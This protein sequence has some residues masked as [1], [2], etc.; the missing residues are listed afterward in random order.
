ML[1]V[2]N[3][4]VRV[5]M[6]DYEDEIARYVELVSPLPG[7]VAVG[8][9]GSVGT[10][11]YSDVDYVLIVDGSFDPRNADLL[12]QRHPERDRRIVLHA[13][14]IVSAELYREFATHLFFDEPV[15]Y[16]GSFDRLPHNHNPAAR[17]AS[18]RANLIDFCETRIVQQAA[19]KFS[20]TIDQR[21]AMTA[22]WSSTH[23]E[24][25]ADLLDIPLS[26]AARHTTAALRAERA[27][28]RSGE[29]PRNADFLELYQ[30]NCEFTQ[31]LIIAALRN[32]SAA[33]GGELTAG[34][35]DVRFVGGTKSVVCSVS[36]IEVSATARTLAVKGRNVPI[37]T[38]VAAPMSM[39]SH[40][41]AYGF[42]PRNSQ[43]P[44]VSGSAIGVVLRERAS[45]ARRYYSFLA[46]L[47]LARANGPYVVL[48][49]IPPTRA[50]QRVAFQ[51]HS[52]ID[53]ISRK[54][55]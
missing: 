12:F 46:P 26:S 1:K 24:T 51:A 39:A 6:T 49:V 33:L 45:F 5:K 43:A 13:P 15:A 28:W 31:E 29:A 18:L 54:W 9:V 42:S 7:V 36:T 8:T 52:F 10:V 40:L 19:A 2:V 17:T 14:L 47:G 32:E 50:A 53:L 35:P 25:I 21:H 4:P 41:L 3:A 11:G 37:S 22:M 23:S 38:V 20:G 48:P 16:F 27:A 34:Q 30:A 44:S 55:A